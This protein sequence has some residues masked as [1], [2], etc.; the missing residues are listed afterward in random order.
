[1]SDISNFLNSFSSMSF[2]SIPFLPHYYLYPTQISIRLPLCYL[3]LHPLKWSPT[4]NIFFLK[5]NCDSGTGIFSPQYKWDCI[6]KYFFDGWS[7]YKNKS[8]LLGL[9]FKDSR[10]FAQS[11]LFS[12][13]LPNS[14]S[15]ALCHQALQTSP[16]MHSHF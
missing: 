1:M 3:L 7:A 13:I 5:S 14:P 16:N 15:N 8:S 12:F 6:I 10:N 4:S 9:T 2:L 11:E